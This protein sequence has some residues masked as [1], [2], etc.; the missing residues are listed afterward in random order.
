MSE[1]KKMYEQTNPTHAREQVPTCQR[2]VRHA[3]REE[4][5]T[6][7]A[8][9][10]TLSK[11]QHTKV[12]HKCFFGYPRFMSV[13]SHCRSKADVVERGQRVDMVGTK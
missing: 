1:N 11:Q 10:A 3:V 9:C 8:L 4:R 2:N 12:P 5:V 7:F 13:P 6:Y